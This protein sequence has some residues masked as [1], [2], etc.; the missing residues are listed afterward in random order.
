MFEQDEM[1]TKLLK[2]TMFDVVL[3]LWNVIEEEENVLID[4]KK[5]IGIV[6][7]LLPNNKWFNEFKQEFLS[8]L[9]I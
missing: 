7:H 9:L 2:N 4:Y 6:L 5:R 8:N 1:S 3:K